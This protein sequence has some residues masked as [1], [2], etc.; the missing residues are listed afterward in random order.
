MIGSLGVGILLV[1]EVVVLRPGPGL[2]DEAGRNDA[3]IVP[4][5]EVVGLAARF[6]VAII[7]FL[8]CSVQG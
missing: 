6:G 1:E 2:L 8:L 7:V 3:G 4:A 5:L